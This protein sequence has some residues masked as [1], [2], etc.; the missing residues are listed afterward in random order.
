[1]AAQEL[2][3]VAV[4][5]LDLDPGGVP[6][7]AELAG[8]LLH[9]DQERE[10]ARREGR[11]RVVRLV[12]SPARAAAGDA[13]PVRA[14]RSYLVTGG[15]GGIGL[16]VGEWLLE[17]G[18]GA[19]VLSGRRAP[20]PDAEAV[21]A[22]LRERHARVR[23]E[24]ADVTDGEA[25]TRLVAG[26]G[27]T[28]AEPP[29]GGVFH[30][31]GVLSDATLPNQD[32]AGFE[33]VLWPKVLGGW[34]LHRA[35]RSLDLDRFVLFSSV[36]G[37]FGTP[38]QANYAAANVFLD[39]LALY[40]RSLGLPGQTVVWGPWWGVGW[41]ETERERIAPGMELAGVSWVTRAQALRALSRLLRENVPVG[42]VASVDWTSLATGMARPP[43][44]VTDLTGA[45]ADAVPGEPGDLAARLQ[46]AQAGDRERLAV[47]LV[48]EAVR[49]VLRLGELPAPDVGFFELGMDSLMAVELRNRVNRG[50]SGAF[51]ASN[52]AVFDHP[53]PAALGRHLLAGLGEPPPVAAA[54]RAAPRRGEDRVAVVGMACRFPGGA[55]AGG[56]WAQLA[57]GE[58][59]VT[60]GRPEELFPEEQN[61]GPGPFGAYLPALDRFDA[62]FFRIPPVEAE[63]MDPQQ[64]LLLEVSW[65]A[66]EDAGMAPARL[67]GSATGVYAG[68]SVSDYRE[69][70][71][72]VAGDAAR[73]LYSATGTSLS[74]AIGRVAFALGLEGPA[75]AV[76]TACSGSLVAV[77]Q[78]AMGLA[79]GEADLALAG[80][81]NAILAPEVTR[82]L[83][84]ASML[85]PNGR[86]RTFDAAADG[87]VRGE[88][89]G[90]VVL[91]RLADAERDGDRILGVLLGSAVNQDGASAGLTVPNGPAQE[92][93]DP[94]GARAGGC[95]TRNRGLPGGARHG[96]GARGP[97]RGG[98]RRRRCTGRAGRRSARCSSVR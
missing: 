32:W 87:F 11:R 66:L 42:A 90:V 23:V 9:P 53:T 31:V 79:R 98:R 74:A 85:S 50:L 61:G 10:I 81:V 15:L 78:A 8:E 64:R 93:G 89:C 1:M 69:L 30:S 97:H 35:T 65:E 26:I 17:Q 96:D 73:S 71:G 95:R 56:F 80:G 91:K 86:C 43:A 22:R 83:A 62:E 58:Q 12:R 82:L 3:N 84:D 27:G 46:G 21:V 45:A 54:P 59:S 49:S 48:R 47:E 20:G 67:R 92:R 38:G 77:H 28:E 19:V 4:R 34:R 5:L 68:I 7:A 57:A 63:L 24:T 2:G 29:L 60:R 40:R 37:L 25:V 16:A 36:S 52:T 88:G 18:A 94:G 39:Q 13:R 76:D 51:V 44:P 14:D 41:G 33:R 6:A 70:I 75:L 72:P 55:D